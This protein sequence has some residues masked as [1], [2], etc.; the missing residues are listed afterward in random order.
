MFIFFKKC[1]CEGSVPIQNM[2][3]MEKA[4]VLLSSTPSVVHR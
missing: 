3:F 1:K 2:T 4:K